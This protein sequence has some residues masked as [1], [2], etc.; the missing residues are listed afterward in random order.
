M[1]LGS[2]KL[3]VILSCCVG[4]SSR[5]AG[6]IVVVNSVCCKPIE[7]LAC[8]VG[9]NGTDCASFVCCCDGVI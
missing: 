3:G 1:G 6:I 9:I 4:R 5:V 8:W 2:S 7:G